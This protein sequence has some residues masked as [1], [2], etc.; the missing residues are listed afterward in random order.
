[1]SSMETQ[2]IAAQHAVNLLLRDTF[3]VVGI[4]RPLDVATG[5]NDNDDSEPIIGWDC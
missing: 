5:V 1:M 2:V 4:C 3:G